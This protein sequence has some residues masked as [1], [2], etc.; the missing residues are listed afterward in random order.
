MTYRSFKSPGIAA[1][2]A[3]LA[4]TLPA[5]EAAAAAC[6]EGQTK[7]CTTPD[8]GPGIMT[9]EWPGWGE[10][11]PTTWDPYW[12]PFGSVDEVSLNP[13]MTHVTVRGWTIDRSSFANPIQVRVTVDGQERAVQLANTYRP[14][15]GAAY[16]GAGDFHGYF[17]QIPAEKWGHHTVCVEGINVGAGRNATIR[18]RSYTIEGKVTTEWG[19]DD[20]TRCV[21]DPVQA[22]N[23]LPRSQGT[24][25]GFYTSTSS[26][27]LG[28]FF[29]DPHL[30][31]I[32]RLAVGDGR[33]FIV[34]RSGS[35]AF[36]VVEMG[37]Q[38]T[39]GQ[40]FGGIGPED[41]VVH[42]QWSN[43][44]YD[45]AGGIQTLGTL[46]AVPYSGD[47]GA[48]IKFFDM[49]DP[50]NPYNVIDMWDGL[51]QPWN[52][53]GAVA[54]ARLANDR[55]A[56]IVGESD[57]DYLNF[58]VGDSGPWGWTHHYR[59]H[60]SQLRTAI[61]GDTEFGNYQS[62]N[63]VTRCG[64][65]ALFLVGLH[66]NS[67]TGDDWVDLFRVEVTGSGSTRGAVLTKVAKRHLICDDQCNLDASGGTY[68][69][70]DGRL[71]VYGT[72]HS[73]TGPKLNG[74]R[75]V[76]ARQF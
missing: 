52:H 35:M 25:I 71:I 43:T 42:R 61:P 18:C 40:P 29:G 22:I 27:G 46:V 16:G 55:I 4:F 33:H 53:A 19:E 32:Q 23:T 21:D 68:V 2:L 75:S 26:E 12:D 9:C 14:D 10:C 57:S 48:F 6:S 72:E 13:S 45:H 39:E 11:M 1:T 5:T 64:D 44:V 37:S 56:M 74:V 60:E 73:A 65:G 50:A 70:P 49:S 41:R 30:Q 69:T 62:L 66:Q 51:S 76:T 67:W 34:S 7:A 20:V 59:W 36:Y 54:L 3:L 15:V 63:F 47:I 38:N 31:S 17:I 8:G 24:D 28:Y 58:Y